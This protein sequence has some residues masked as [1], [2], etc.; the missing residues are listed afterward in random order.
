MCA[1]VATDY[2]EG[3]HEQ[4]GLSYEQIK[5]RSGRRADDVQ[6]PD[7]RDTMK[8][9]RLKLAHIA[10]HEAGHAVV[11]YR[12]S[13]HVGGHVTIV[14]EQKENSRSLGAVF[15]LTSDSLSPEDM[16]AKILSCYAGRHAQ[17]ELDPSCC[18]DGCYGDYAQADKLLRWYGWEDRE[19]QLREQS[20]ALTRK[21]W[22]EIVAV[23]DELL[24]L[25][26]LDETEVEIISDAAAGDPTAIPD[27]ALFRA[28][29]GER[30]EKWR[31]RARMK[32]RSDIRRQSSDKRQR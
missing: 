7:N 15:D 12:A 16:E 20:L 8:K 31:K 1:N 13:G 22:P 3:L 9:T 5:T 29:Y 23:A 18:T 25:R 14:P 19:Q 21:H 11:L 4:F 30:V 28:L 17:R 2:D 32:K 26:V 24:R 10:Y 6:E 27:F